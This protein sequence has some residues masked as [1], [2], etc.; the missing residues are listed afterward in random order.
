MKKTVR[1]EA[2]LFFQPR[3]AP[4]MSSLAKTVVAAFS[5][6]HLQLCPKFI[7]DHDLAFDIGGLTL[8]VAFS[9]EALDL[10][11]FMH[12]KTP[13][14]EFGLPP[15][16][17]RVLAGH[18]SAV[19]VQVTGSSQA[20]MAKTRLAVCY[21]AASRLIEAL[22]PDLIHWAKSDTVYTYPEFCD[23]AAASAARRTPRRTAFGTNAK[24]QS[25][26]MPPWLSETEQGE[27]RDAIDGLRARALRVSAFSTDNE[28]PRTAQRP[29]R[30]TTHG[31]GAPIGLGMALFQI[32]AGS[33]PG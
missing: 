9:P 19:V 13:Q 31:F 27:T 6:N 28:P 14:T 3:I 16:T 2:T 8:T 30:M 32:I 1:I 10:T 29:N 33:K 12:A 4:E 22:T 15:R 5:M 24:T 21:I 11:P 25:A 20:A 17:Q 23:R 26:A 7:S 18:G